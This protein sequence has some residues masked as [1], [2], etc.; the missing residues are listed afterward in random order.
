MTSYTTR[1]AVKTRLDITGTGDDNM[2]AD[3]CAAVSRWLD[4]KC[5]QVLYD[6]YN[7]TR[8]FDPLGDCVD[9]SRLVLDRPLA[10]VDSITVNGSA[11]TTSDYTFRPRNETPYHE[12]V[13]KRAST[14]SWVEDSDDEDDIVIVGQWCAIADAT[15]RRYALLS[16]AA[17]QLAVYVYRLKD[18]G[19]T[20]DIVG[21][22][23]AGLVTVPKGFPASVKHMIGTFKRA[24]VAV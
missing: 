20:D 24:A 5:G 12:I 10:S 1:D 4:A 3:V 19:A 8:Y 9:G 15:D 7:T 14:R 22:L 16:E 2:I 23:D 21:I 13:I 11:F 6:E 17:L 18:A